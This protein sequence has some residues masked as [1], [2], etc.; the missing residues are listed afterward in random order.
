MS[1]RDWPRLLLLLALSVF[2][3]GCVKEH[4]SK[5]RGPGFNDQAQELTADIPQR[6]NAGKPYSFSTKG[7]EIEQNF[8]FK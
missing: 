2:A 4:L 5:A 8:G 6:E 3:A 7:R 1:F